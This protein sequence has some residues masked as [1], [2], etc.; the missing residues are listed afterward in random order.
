MI[1][2][3]G[4]HLRAGS[5]VLVGV[6]SCEWSE[7]RKG[8]GPASSECVPLTER[9]RALPGGVIPSRRTFQML[10]AH[11]ATLDT[12]EGDFRQSL[13]RLTEPAVRRVSTF[14]GPSVPTGEVSRS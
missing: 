1:H 9:A 10:R 2:P 4:G 12:L 11:L 7:S 6:N 14:S 13:G 8:G 5:V 3:F